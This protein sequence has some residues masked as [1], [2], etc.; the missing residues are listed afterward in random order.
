MGTWKSRG[1]RGSQLED[2]INP[3]DWRN[4]YFKDYTNYWKFYGVKSISVDLATIKTDLGGTKKALPATITVAV[5]DKNGYIVPGEYVGNIDKLT[6]PAKFY[7]GKMG[8]KEVT[9]DFGFLVYMNNLSETNEDFHLYLYAT[10]EYKWG[11]VTS[12]EIT[13]DVKRTKALE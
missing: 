2:L 3:Y 4:R 1:L 12:N 10:L 13:V 8:S 6:Q 5:F 7:E 11:K 9:S